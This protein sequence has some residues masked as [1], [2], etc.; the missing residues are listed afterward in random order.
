M[1][2]F[3]GRIMKHVLF[4]FKASSH[5]DPNPTRL[6][7]IPCLSCRLMLALNVREGRRCT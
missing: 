2:E 4:T 1:V 6:D 5:G 3:G 7:F